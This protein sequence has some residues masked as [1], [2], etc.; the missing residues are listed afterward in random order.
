M[1]PAL[2]VQLT[3]VAAW[4]HGATAHCQ[5]QRKQDAA[6]SHRPARPGIGVFMARHLNRAH[7]RQRIIGRRR[8]QTETAVSAG[9]TRLGGHAVIVAS[10]IHHA[11]QNH[12]KQR[13][14]QC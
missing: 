13:A 14:L 4:A 2:A 9:P 7:V 10:H 5:T 11:V 1:P 6:N 8:L 12:R 3:V